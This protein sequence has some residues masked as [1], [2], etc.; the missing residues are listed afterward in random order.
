MIFPIFVQ[1]SIL[2]I[3]FSVIWHFMDELREIVQTF[4]DSTRCD[5]CSYT[6]TSSDKVCKHIAL[7]HSKLDEMLQN[8]ELLQRKRA[9][10]SI[11]PKREN[12]PICPICDTK[13]PTREHCA[14]HF[15]DELN[16]LVSDLITDQSLTCPECAYVG[17]KPKNL[18]LHIALV[19][20]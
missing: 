1:F 15:G 3:F 16:E 9:L 13:D 2:I 10:A 18:G 5:W 6:N 12:L 4:E 20:T 14:R 17:E 11:K 19:H 7:G 8:E